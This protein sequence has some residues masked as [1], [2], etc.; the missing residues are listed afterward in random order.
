MN[1]LTDSSCEGVNFV[2]VNRNYSKRQP[3]ARLVSQLIYATE[4]NV[5]IIFFRHTEFDYFRFRVT[6]ARTNT[7]I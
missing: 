3:V 2:K 5:E 6:N 1:D 7:H 4:H